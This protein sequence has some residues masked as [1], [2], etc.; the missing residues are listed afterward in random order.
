M[1][2]K[3]PTCRA[4]K[5][6]N[7]QGSV[8]W[9]DKKNRWIGQ[10]TLSRP[11][12]KKRTKEVAGKLGDHSA[13][14]KL[15][16]NHRLD[17][18][19]APNASDAT[20]PLRTFLDAF[21]KGE[22][23]YQREVSDHTRVQYEGFIGRHLE[24]LGAKPMLDVTPVDI[25]NAIAAVGNKART[26][27]GVH[28]MLKAVFQWAL[29]A[30]LITRNPV[31]AVKA[32]KYKRKEKLRVY[33]ALEVDYLLKEA[34]GDRLEA[35]LWLALRYG[36]RPGELYGLRRADLDLR[37]GKMVVRGSLVATK[38]SGHVPVLKSTKTG[39]EREI[40]LDPEA[41]HM[42]HERLRIGLAEGGSEYV[43]TSDKNLPIRH[44]NLLRNWWRPLC[45]RAAAEAAKA[46]YTLPK[47]HL[48]AL[49]HT[50]FTHMRA[51]GVDSGAMRTI[52]GHAQASTT[53]QY[54]TQP[55]EADLKAAALRI[56]PPKKRRRSC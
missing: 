9:H 7:G 3:S 8:Y 48:Y 16:V 30:E 24:R 13:G 46:G 35:L 27:K 4:G 55:T 36:L 25:A 50:A 10:V 45:D 12:E 32:P 47:L 42:L 44:T 38:Q 41:V 20:K 56:A 21:A 6:A 52:A 15:A 1:S 28:A 39:Q 37:A 51:K 54:Y 33:N 29:D 11:G 49:R 17:K 31:R 34:R 22:P 26:A 43:F 53:L 14:A 18:Y 40:W 23:P 5:A 19:R 2:R